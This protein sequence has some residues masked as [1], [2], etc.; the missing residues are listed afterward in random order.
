[1]P[2]RWSG[3][4]QS[5]GSYRY[6]KRPGGKRVKLTRLKNASSQTARIKFGMTKSLNY[7]GVA[8]RKEMVIGNIRMAWIN[9]VGTNDGIYV[10]QHTVQANIPL[11]NWNMLKELYGQYQIRGYKIKLFP[12]LTNVEA[13]STATREVP[14]LTY[15]KDTVND[16]AWTGGLTQAAQAGAKSIQFTKPF[17]YYVSCKPEIALNATGDVKIP[18]DSRKTWIPTDNSAVKHR[19]LQ[20]MLSNMDVT[21]W[22]NTTIS[23]PAHITIYYGFKM[24]E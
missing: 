18:V 8:F 23:V 4:R 1:M 9:G 3:K 22:G 20:L 5:D 10:T 14:L 11:D 19:G 7:K 13:T 16:A 17:S 15:K 6:T 21:S 2:G 12:P 24:Q